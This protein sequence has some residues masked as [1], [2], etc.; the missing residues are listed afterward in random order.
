MMKNP[1]IMAEVREVFRGKKNYDDEEDLEKLTYLKLVI[2]E[3]LR[4]HTPAPL[5]GPRDANKC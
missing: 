5:L 2:K 1:N 3:T 4:L